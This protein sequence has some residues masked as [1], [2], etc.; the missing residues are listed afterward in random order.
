LIG[1]VNS[2]HLDS[3]ANP[4][5]GAFLNSSTTSALAPAVPAPAAGWLLGT[6]LVVV[7]GRRLRRRTAR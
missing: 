6:S 3:F 7:M 5:G 1:H 2:L 4:T